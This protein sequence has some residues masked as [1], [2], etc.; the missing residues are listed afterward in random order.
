MA[1]RDKNL[2]AWQ[3]YV[4][5]MAF[6]SVGLMLGMFFL[7]RSY[8][9]TTKR[10]TETTT[11]YNEALSEAKKSEARVTRLKAMMGFGQHS[12]E[13]LQA[14]A[15]E[16]ANDPALGEV[17]KKFAEQMKL[18]AKNDTD[19][20]LIKLPEFLMNTIRIRNEELDRLKKSEA[21][22]Q[23]EQADTLAR[24]RPLARTP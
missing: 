16:F 10:F 21:A 17:E 7:Y 5:T 2:V 4:I 6:I 14:M 12:S 11:K 18:F 19:A 23:K 8:A 20:N 15:Q 24:E 9:D 22:I 1:V 13:D 3:A